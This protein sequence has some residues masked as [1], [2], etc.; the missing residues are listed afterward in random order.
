MIS[1]DAHT[2]E[3]VARKDFVNFQQVPGRETADIYPQYPAITD[4]LK[5]QGKISVCSG[6]ACGQE[7]V[8]LR[9]FD[10]SNRTTGLNGTLTGT[11][12]LV[13]NALAT[14][15][16]F[17]QAA[18]GTWHCRNDDPTKFEPAPTKLT[19]SPNPPN[20][21]MKSTLFSLL[22]ISWNILEII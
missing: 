1:V 7:R 17:A 8:Q 5:N 11:H 13:N 14:K 9:A 16:P 18:L 2:G 3:T 6:I 10:P 21:R 19:I 22:R 4:E 20:S 12:A 15:Q